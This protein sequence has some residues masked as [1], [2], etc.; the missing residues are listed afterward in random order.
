MVTMRKQTL[1]FSVILLALSLSNFLQ[2]A[3]PEEKPDVSG[4]NSRINMNINGYSLD[5]L[6]I[7]SRNVQ[8]SQFSSRNKTGLNGDA[9]YFLYEDP[10]GDTVIFDATGPGCLKSFWGTD[11]QGGTLLK[12]YFDDEVAPRL[13]VDLLEVYQGKNPLFAADLCSY[14]TTGQWG[15]APCSGNCFVPVPFNKRLR[16]AMDKN[17]NKITFYHII[18]E[19]FTPGTCKAINFVDESGKL[20][21]EAAP[22]QALRKVFQE[23][24]TVLK[25]NQNLT[26]RKIKIEKVAQMP[27]RLQDRQILVH[28]GQGAIRRISF[29][30]PAE[31]QIVERLLIYFRF[32]EADFYQVFCPLGMLIANATHPNQVNSMPVKVEEPKNG[33]FKAHVLFPMPF[34][35]S[36]SLE[37]AQ[38]ETSGLMEEGIA[39][40]GIG[41]E[42]SL[43]E[44]AYPQEESGYFTTC[45]R[46]GETAYGEDWLLGR[47]FGRG[48]YL[49]TVQSMQY[50]HYCEGDE[51]TYVDGSATPAFNGTG[52]EDYYLACYW[53][54]LDFDLPF[55]GCVG[56]IKL[57]RENPSESDWHAVDANV[58][59]RPCCYYR[60]H[61]DAPI[62]FQSQLE[63]RIEHGAN[64]NIHSQYRSL[65]FFYVNADSGLLPT[66][67]IDV[68]NELSEKGHQ[69]DSTSSTPVPLTAQYEGTWDLVPVFDTGRY[70]TGGSIKFQAAIQPSNRGVRLRRRFDQ[71]EGRQ[72]AEV[73]VDNQL[74]GRWYDPD[75][76]SHKRWCDSDFAIPPDYTTGKNEISVELKI[77]PADTAK[78]F[79]DFTYWIYSIQ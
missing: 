55:A 9:G 30:L 75:E 23:Q 63:A 60:F 39:T 47:V 68:G 73:Y 22:P 28:T 31:D 62:V 25:E 64:S 67:L 46:R 78:N 50:Q 32:D 44:E 69:Y 48:V 5:S 2:A 29:D 76:N 3:S 40:Q 74:V 8:V 41:V 17:G 49:G 61:L 7:I 58:Y 37:L 66:D 24:E 77:V 36:F 20:N 45:Y 10:N 16:I 38:D 57:E 71:N 12:F 54:N 43:S 26:T 79:T 51:R 1:T 4:A 70:H 27:C 6:P 52:S 34:W 18:Y 13:T 15:G 19:K 42:V 35:K 65:S 72:M 14:R 11:I 56:N 33:R 53:P 21:P 59:R